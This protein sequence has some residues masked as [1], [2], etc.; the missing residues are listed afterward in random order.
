MQSAP[1][2]PVLDQ[3]HQAKRI[4][5]AKIKAAARGI[6]QEEY[7][8][9]PRPK[10]RKGEAYLTAILEQ[11]RRIIEDRE[12][13]LARI[14]LQIERA[15]KRREELDRR[16]ADNEADLDE[17]TGGP[18]VRR[19][20]MAE[21]IEETL[22]KYSLVFDVTHEHV[23][24]QYQYR[25]IVFVR[26]EIWWRCHLESCANST[27]IGNYFNRDHTTILNGIRRYRHYQLAKAGQV[28]LS[29]YDK[30]IPLDMVI[31]LPERVVEHG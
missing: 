16:I 17:L 27:R 21:I 31:P 26:H 5:D 22:D 1:S 8:L 10:S 13:K 3:F 6:A 15:K 25:E 28:Q 20:R 14:N 29:D 18:V 30:K 9:P 24:G 23:M 2:N 19:K 4:R 7:S 11:E 12:R